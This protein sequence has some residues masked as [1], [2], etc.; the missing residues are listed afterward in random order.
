MLA[1]FAVINGCWFFFLSRCYLL[2]VMRRLRALNS[3]Y[4]L[5]ETIKLFI[6]N[7]FFLSVNVSYI[8]DWW[9]IN[10]IEVEIVA[11]TIFSKIKTALIICIFDSSK[12]MKFQRFDNFIRKYQIWV[13]IK[14][15]VYN[16][17][18][19]E[20]VQENARLRLFFWQ[21]WNLN[22]FVFHFQLLDC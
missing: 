1:K 7:I 18:F 15:F 21:W 20:L 17:F 11:I 6:I 19:V 16:S 13:L 8:V 22:F 10:I 12:V 3:E 4:I 9:I 5:I 14:D 2:V